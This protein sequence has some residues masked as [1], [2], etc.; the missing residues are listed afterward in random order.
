MASAAPA[1]LDAQ[2]PL[3]L[4]DLFALDDESGETYEIIGGELFVS[5][6]PITTHQDVVQF[7]SDAIGPYVRQ[8]RLGKVY[9]S[10]IAVR[11]GAHDIVQ[12][13]LLFISAAKRPLVETRVIEGAPDLVI[14]VLS[15]SSRRNDLVRKRALYERT[16][17]REYWIVDIP[18]RR[19]TLLE[20]RSGQYEEIDTS[21]GTIRS[22]VIDGLE[23]SVAAVFADLWE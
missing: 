9:A 14:E 17:I 21:G 12:P 11:L 3:T 5:P 16:G 7:I 18:A 13:D 4:D 10:P 23:L 6:T 22:A 20:L 8:N 19:I 15:P 1:L 2:R